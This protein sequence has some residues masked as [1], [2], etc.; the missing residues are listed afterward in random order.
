LNEGDFQAAMK[1]AAQL[2]EKISALAAAEGSLAT[3]SDARILKCKDVEVGMML[4]DV[5]EVTA[6]DQCQCCQ[7]HCDRMILTIGEQ[8]VSFPAD[9][10]IIVAVPVSDL[11][12]DDVVWNFSRRQVE[13][14][15]YHGH[16]GVGRFARGL[17]R[18]SPTA[19]RLHRRWR[20]SAS[21]AFDQGS[22]ALERR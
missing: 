15:I 14:E 13:P 12:S 4:A 16:D 21:A 10:E 8:P 3:V 2:H 9:A 22:G 1:T 20:P 17:E 11:M 7:H 19:K 5:G 6:I 18:A